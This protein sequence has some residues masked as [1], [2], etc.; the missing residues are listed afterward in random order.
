MTEVG[1]GVK[2]V[3][4][5]TFFTQDAYIAFLQKIFGDIFTYWLILGILLAREN[6]PPAFKTVLYTHMNTVYYNISDQS[7][8]CQVTDGKLYLSLH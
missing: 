2:N 7:T 1:L 4:F 6:E 3:M 8:H 5:C